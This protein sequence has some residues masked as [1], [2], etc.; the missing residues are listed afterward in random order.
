MALLSLGTRLEECRRAAAL[1]AE[2]GLSTTIADA[3]FAKPLDHDLIRSLVK[4]HRILITLEEGSIGGF[5]SQVLH[6]L[7]H[8]GL[9][10]AAPPI[11]PLILP[12]T[13]I[14]QDT[15]ENQYHQT[16]LTASSIVST[17]LRTLNLKEK[18]S[19]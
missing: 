4:H 6:F 13:F 2:R 3:R 11:R 15:Q 19:A 7:A 1:L 14:D 18:A 10:D 16:D 5:G 8:G 9:L 17:V 12:D